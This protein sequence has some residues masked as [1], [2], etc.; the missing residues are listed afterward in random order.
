MCQHWKADTWFWLKGFEVDVN[1]YQVEH[2][3]RSWNESSVADSRHG[4]AGGG[5]GCACP[6]PNSFIFMQFWAKKFQ[7]HRLASSTRELAHPTT[8][9]TNLRNPGS[10]TGTLSQ[11]LSM[12]VTYLIL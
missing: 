7:N 9:T 8:N 6:G 11:E 3:H 5:Q 2:C 1:I 12:S 10:A 4:G